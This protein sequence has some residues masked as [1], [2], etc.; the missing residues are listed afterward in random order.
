MI[1]AE[2]WGAGVLPGEADFVWVVGVALGGENVL[3]VAMTGVAVSDMMGEAG[4]GLATTARNVVPG[5]LLSGDGVLSRQA[6]KIARKS[7]RR[8]KR[9]CL[10]DI[11]CLTPHSQ[12]VPSNEPEARRRPSGE[13]ARLTIGWG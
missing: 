11:H 6:G 2:V 13:K 12:T 9:N 5:E 4:Y 3:G 8:Q 1:G 10:T 7:K